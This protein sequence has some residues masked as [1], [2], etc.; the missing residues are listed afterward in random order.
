MEDAKRG[1]KSAVG[2]A[3]RYTGLLCFGRAAG[4]EGEEKAGRTIAEILKGLGYEVKEEKFSIL[5]PPWTWTKGA[6]F[7]SALFLFIVWMTF[8]EMAWV[9]LLFS[10]LYLLG[11]ICWE[12][13]WFW[14]GGRF[15]S[16]DLSRGWRQSGNISACLPAG[17][18]G[19]VLYLMAHYDSKSQTFNL[20]LRTILYL[21]GGISGGLF[22]LW[23]GAYALSG[24]M[25]IPETRIPAVFVASFLLSL[26]VNLLFLFSRSGNRSEGALDNASGV[27][28][29]LEAASR[30]SV[31][32]VKGIDL[33]FV[34]T[35]AEEMG[36]LGSLMYMRRWGKTMAVENARLINIDSV[37][38]EGKIRVCSTGRAGRRWV[39]EI[40]RFARDRGLA[41][42]PLRFHK[43]VMMDHLP[44]AR[45]G[46][47]S[48]SFTSISTEGW[49]LHSSRDT[50]ALVRSE[51]L[52]E[53]VNWTLALVGALSTQNPQRKMI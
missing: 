53:M 22:S 27:G 41:L 23:A 2:S 43:G 40:L 37:G 29:L 11:L 45:L 16:N 52:T 5:F 36:L 33:R 48:V 6:P 31:E 25:G 3:L 12:R 19:R 47:P 17:R 38:K 46:I 39:G 35:G 51:G 10:I 24:R 9:S 4:T 18:E 49:H 44:F 32:R 28:V 34:F 21:I 30:W 20:Y 7:F 50:L 26:A 42:R 8:A 14:A 1:L 15:V 13:I